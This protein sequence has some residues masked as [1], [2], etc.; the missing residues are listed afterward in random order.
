MQGRT[1]KPFDKPIQAN[2]ESTVKD[3]GKEGDGEKEQEDEKD[4]EYTHDDGIDIDKEVSDIRD[5]HQKFLTSST[6]TK[7]GTLNQLSNIDEITANLL[8]A[9]RFILKKSAHLEQSMVEKMQDD[10]KTYQK[11]YQNTSKDIKL[12]ESLADGGQQGIGEKDAEG[13]KAT[14]I[15]PDCIYVDESNKMLVEQIKSIA[16]CPMCHEVNVPIEE[17]KA[18]CECGAVFCKKCLNKQKNGNT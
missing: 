3:E 18:C 14:K 13:D 4:L 10:D 15:S 8:K 17:A 1:F 6:N 7:A 12:I 5:I 2:Q 16:V 9:Q 11:I